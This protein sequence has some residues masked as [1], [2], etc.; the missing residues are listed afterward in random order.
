MTEGWLPE[1]RSRIG[2][3]AGA[4]TPDSEIGESIARILS[5][6]GVPAEELEA[7]VRAGHEATV[8]RKER[9]RARTVPT[10]GATA[11]PSEERPSP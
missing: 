4:S 6:R 7:L 11:P 1:A 2:V 9:E 8:A 3:T 5:F 10:K